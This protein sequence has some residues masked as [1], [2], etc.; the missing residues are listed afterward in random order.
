MLKLELEATKVRTL[1]T[2]VSLSSMNLCCEIGSD[3]VVFLSP[4]FGQSLST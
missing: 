4:V 1:A 2:V 3:P